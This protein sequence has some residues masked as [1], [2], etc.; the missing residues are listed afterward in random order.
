MAAEPAE[1]G[2][3][4]AAWAFG[5]GFCNFL[6][7]SATKSLSC[8]QFGAGVGL[9]PTVCGEVAASCGQWGPIGAVQQW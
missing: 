7:L 6:L 4:G 5:R 9:F 2:V 3:L 8:T 1:G